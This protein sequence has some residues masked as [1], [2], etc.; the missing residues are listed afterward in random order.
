ML[1]MGSQGH[2]IT[3]GKWKRAPPRDELPLGVGESQVQD[4]LDGEDPRGHERGRYA[5]QAARVAEIP[6]VAGDASTPGA[7]LRA[8]ACVRSDV[9]GNNTWR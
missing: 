1:E 3:L 2:R 4:D 6:E 8:R 5:D 7:A 9:G